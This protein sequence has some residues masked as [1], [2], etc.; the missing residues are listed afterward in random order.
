MRFHGI[1]KFLRAKFQDSVYIIDTVSIFSREDR[2]I[3]LK[4]F[5]AW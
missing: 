2:D 5:K 4:L 3:E 1:S